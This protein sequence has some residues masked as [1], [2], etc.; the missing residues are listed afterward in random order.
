MPIWRDGNNE[1]Q[2]KLTSGEKERE[3]EIESQ[4]E[5]FWLVVVRTFHL[6][7]DRE[8]GQKKR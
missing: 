7:V 2:T 4:R 8:K 1:A 6:N 3:R 5:Y